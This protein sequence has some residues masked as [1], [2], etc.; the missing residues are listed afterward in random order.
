MSRGSMYDRVFTAAGAATIALTAAPWLS[1]SQSPDAAT[2]A[3]ATDDRTVTLWEMLAQVRESILPLAVLAVLVITGFG[4]ACVLWR[5]STAA[6]AIGFA[7][8][9]W[10]A[11]VTAAIVMALTDGGFHPG[12][13]AW[14]TLVLGGLTAIVATAQAS[15]LARTPTTA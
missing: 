7:A 3:T 9:A 5:G 10:L 12:T 8:L 2:A 6:A 14:V 15:G 11:T 1:T 13:G 4:V